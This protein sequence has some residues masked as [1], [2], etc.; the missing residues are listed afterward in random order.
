[1][2]PTFWPNTSREYFLKTQPEINESEKKLHI[3]YHL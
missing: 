3:T 1:M 2:K